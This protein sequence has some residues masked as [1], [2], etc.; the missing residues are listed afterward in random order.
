MA[1]RY[2]FVIND[3]SHIAE[4]DKRL[5]SAFQKN[6]FAAAIKS[7]EQTDNPLRLNNFAMD[8]RELSRI[9]LH[10][11]APEKDIRNCCWFAEEVNEIGQP[12]ITRA[13][14]IR[15]AVQAGLADDFVR[16]TLLIDVQETIDEF[17][18][19]INDLSK[20]THV[21]E[22]TFD[23]DDTLAETLAEEALGIFSSLLRTIDD[24]RAE[25]LKAVE[26]SARDALNEE[27]IANTIQELDQL[28]TH[29]TIDGAHIEEFHLTHIGAKELAF[30]AAGSVDVELQYGSDSDYERGD[31][32]RMDDSYP[33]TCKF[34]ADITSPLDLT[35]K[36]L[37][38][39]NS[40]FYE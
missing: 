1:V 3:I 16:D 22:N 40:S 31:G 7:F 17:K 21:S 25:V 24:C 8:L 6:V 38:V 34:T 30:E 11:L 26:D 9:M 28:A 32:L 2:L 18:G 14:R 20:F 5:T 13:Q 37:Q 23:T 4:I 12:I 19:L 29:H 35:V 15:Y 10:D 27:M 33:L 36:A 39:D